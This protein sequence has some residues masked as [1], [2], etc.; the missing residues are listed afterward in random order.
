MMINMND[1]EANDIQMRIVRLVRSVMSMQ[2]CEEV[3]IY[4]GKRELHA[5]HRLCKFE[6]SVV[7][8][9]RVDTFMGY[10]FIRTKDATHLAVYPI[11]F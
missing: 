6:D 1:D 10:K 2:S 7:I 4:L 8:D 5:L 11:P 3:I 9:V